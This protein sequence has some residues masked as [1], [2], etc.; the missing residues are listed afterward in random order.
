MVPAIL[1]RTLFAVLCLTIVGCVPAPQEPGPVSSGTLFTAALANLEDKYVDPFDPKSKMIAG[2]RAL[3]NVDSSVEFRLSRQYLEISQ[4]VAPPVKIPRPMGNG[5]ANWADA[6]A[7]LLNSA[8]AEMPAFVGMPTWK[9]NQIVLDGI[10]ANLDRYSRYLPPHQARKSREK[11]E[12]FGGIGIHI[13]KS[14]SRTVIGKVLPELPGEAADL[15][16]EDEITHIDGDAIEGWSIY[17]VA[18]KLRGPVDKPI[19][20]V[21][22]RPAV[23]RALKKTMRRKPVIPRSVSDILKDGILK[24]EIN[25]FNEGTVRSIERILQAPRDTR[26]QQIRGVILDL[27]NNPGGLLQEAIETADLFLNKAR[28]ISTRGRHTESMQQFDAEPGEMLPETPMAVLINGRTAS[29]AEI[30]ALALRDNGRA[31][32]I[33]STSYGKGTVQTIIGMPDLG[34]LNITWARI[35]APS[36]KILDGQGI[37]PSLCSS[38]VRWTEEREIPSKIL[39]RLEKYR[40]SPHFSAAGKTACPPNKERPVADVAIARFT[41]SNRMLYRAATA[42]GSKQVSRHNTNDPG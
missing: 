29:S 3:E 35:H 9:L 30:V 14:G 38:D 20:L 32:I 31:V 11:R 15:R 16:V 2:L 34:D 17:D 26:T 10:T 5:A 22:R 27:R 24:L 39:K 8:R 21:L 6:G 36:E 18:L 33:G 1:R 41:L 40:S 25:I 37:V 4:E 13:E 42:S 12:G 28:I 19:D 7:R 23:P